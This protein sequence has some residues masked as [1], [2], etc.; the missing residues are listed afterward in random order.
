MVQRPLNPISVTC[1]LH[2][3]SLI[4][5]A[6]EL[7]LALYLSVSVTCQLHVSYMHHGGC[8]KTPNATQV[9]GIICF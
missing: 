7:A 3:A 8:A 5:R 6:F 1:Q 4:V 2:A 9:G